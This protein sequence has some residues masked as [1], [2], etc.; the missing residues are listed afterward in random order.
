MALKKC[1]ACG[2]EIN[3][4]ADKCPHCGVPQKKISI[5]TWVV[6]GILIFVAIEIV[7]VHNTLTSFPAKE[8][9]PS[10]SATESSGPKI[11]KIDKSEKAQSQRKEQ[12]AKLIKNGFFEK[13]EVSGN[14]PQVWIT[15]P[16]Y[17][18]RYDAQAKIISDVY[19]YYFDGSNAH[20]SVLVLD[21][22]SGKKVG[23]FAPL[24]GLKMK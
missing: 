1:K 6:L 12:I 21:S 19:A 20:D 8:S 22:R 18:L 14:T 4:K 10:T 17:A 9:T 5:F 23:S 24:T 2:Q 7:T 3:G 11:I 16:F 15:P 13:V